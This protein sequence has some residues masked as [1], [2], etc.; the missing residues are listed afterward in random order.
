MTEE[1]FLSVII[2]LN[3]LQWG[4]CVLPHPGLAFKRGSQLFK[5]ADL[6]TSVK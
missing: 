4:V 5:S 2:E 1:T 3:A 6:N